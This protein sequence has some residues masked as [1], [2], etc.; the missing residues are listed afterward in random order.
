VLSAAAQQAA[1]Q[2]QLTSALSAHQQGTP[3]EAPPSEQLHLGYT[4]ASGGRGGEGA[5]LLLAGLVWLTRRRRN[6]TV[7]PA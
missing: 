1:S 2:S 7:G 4:C 5:W 3:P 6:G